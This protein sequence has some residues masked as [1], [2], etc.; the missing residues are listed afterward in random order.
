MMLPHAATSSQG[1]SRMR[2]QEALALVRRGQFREFINTSARAGN[3]NEG[4]PNLRVLLAYALALT[5]DRSIELPLAKLD[6]GKLAPSVRSMLETTLG[7]VSWH[8]GDHHSSWR[9]LQAG[10]RLAREANAPERLAWAYLHFLRIAIDAQPLDALLAM[11]REV[12]TAVIRA[13]TSASTAYLHVCVSTLEGQRGHLDEATRHC[14]IAVSL[15]ESEPNT[16]L[17]G[18]A[19]INRSCIACLRCNFRE[20]SEHVRN[21]IALTAVN[22]S[23]RHRAAAEIMSGY[24]QCLM[25]DF[26]SAQRTLT[27]V[28]SKSDSKKPN[29]DAADALARVYLATGDLERCEA[30]LELSGFTSDDYTTTDA[31]YGRKVG[32]VD[33]GQVAVE[34]P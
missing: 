17:L 19:F 33:E 21:V 14:D 13:G 18:S 6:A 8:A 27:N 1:M 11:L 2:Y 10:V 16:W 12:R 4:E 15:L 34:A 32:V 25:G 28:L 24:L 3:P 31:A 29:A 26:E 22:G 7:I 20:A 23:V 30:A 5:G 9:H